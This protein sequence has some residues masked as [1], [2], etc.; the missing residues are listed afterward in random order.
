MNES[1]TPSRWQALYRR[2]AQGFESFFTDPVS[3]YP[4]SVLRILVAVVLLAQ[5]FAIFPFL[6]E[7]YGEKAIIQNSLNEFFNYNYPFPRIS[8]IAE[9]LGQYGYSF[10][11]VVQAFFLAY[12]VALTCL[13]LGWQTR[14]AAVLTWVLQFVIMN[15][16]VLS[17]Y[18][19]DAYAHFVLFYFMWM[20]IDR[21]LSLDAKFSSNP[22]KYRWTPFVTISLRIFQLHMCF[23]YFVAGF[24]KA[25]GY[26]WWNGEAIWQS[27]MLPEYRQFDLSFL[28]S[29]P[30]IPMI[31]GYFTLFIETFYPIGMYLKKVRPYWTLA[32]VGLHFGIIMFQGLQVFGSIMMALTFCLFGLDYDY[33]EFWLYKW[34]K[35][36]FGKGEPL[37]LPHAGSKV[38]P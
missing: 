3:L 30:V 24:G 33:S 19:V 21:G 8:Q 10:N 35:A 38:Q 17:N 36:R 18:G 27:L 7:F 11:G 2:F 5:A 16:S 28:A 1:T 9:Y 29:Y 23:T 4:L 15:S 32:I 20:P 6:Y 37:E 34:F 13:L 31:L 25:M 12:L 26:M 14:I 22:D